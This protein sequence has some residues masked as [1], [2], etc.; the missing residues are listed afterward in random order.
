MELYDAP[1][2]L[3]VAGFIGSPAMN[4]IPCTIEAGD[5]AARVKPAKHAAIEVPAEIPAAA[6]GKPGTL[7]VRPENLS[8]AD[9]DSP[10]ALQGR[11]D[12]IEHLGEVTLLYVDCGYEAPIIAK[13]EGYIDIRRDTPIQLAAPKNALHVFDDKGVAFPPTP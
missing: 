9:G 5:G 13:I 4:M 1:D 6:V 7:G 3:F 8:L 12:I 11:L 10:A 2:N